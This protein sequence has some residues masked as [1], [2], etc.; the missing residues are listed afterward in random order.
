MRAHREN[1]LNPLPS[2]DVWENSNTRFVRMP[3][4]SG[5]IALFDPAADEIFSRI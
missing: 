4:G 2:R 5:F 1:G 3:I